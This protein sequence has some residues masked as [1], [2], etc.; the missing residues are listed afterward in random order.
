MFIKQKSKKNKAKIITLFPKKL[1]YEA[2]A[3]SKENL[4]S[5]VPLII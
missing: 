5:A 1:I 3:I 2:A 4:P